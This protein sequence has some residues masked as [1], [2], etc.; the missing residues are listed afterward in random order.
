LR[1]ERERAVDLGHAPPTRL[2]REVAVTARAG[3]PPCGGC[4]ARRARPR[5][6]PVGCAH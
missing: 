1:R 4:P 5:L 3:C 2:R 6:R